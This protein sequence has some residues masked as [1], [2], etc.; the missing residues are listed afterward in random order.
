MSESDELDTARARFPVGD[1]ISGVVSH[2]PRP[3]MI[4]VF[5]DLGPAPGGFVDVL[6]LPRAVDRW[7]TVATRIRGEILQHRR[8]QV[9]LWPLD[10][11]FQSDSPPAAMNEPTWLNVTGRHPVGSVLTAD[12][13]GVYPANR[14]YGVTFDGA[15]ATLNWEADT[16][17]P[18][19]GSIA[20]F[21]V[22]RHLD[23]TRRILLTPASPTHRGLKSDLP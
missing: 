13:V 22:R 2:V 1:P 6:S 5:V 23:T 19:A 12:I 20:E 8:Q 17:P 18:A 7:P 14:E 4:G 16:D 9:Q 11:R 10:T 21:I 3:G 15:W